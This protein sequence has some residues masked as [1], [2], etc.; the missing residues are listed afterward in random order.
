MMDE[1][2]TKRSSGQ[3][4]VLVV[5]MLVGLIG[6]LALALDGGNVYSMRRQ[7]QLAADAG[8]LAG[9]RAHCDPDVTATPYS[10]ADKY[11]TN[12][13]ATILSF[14]L[15]EDINEVTVETII[16]FDSFFL[17]VLGRPQL[18]VQAL[19]AAR[20]EAGGGAAVLPVAWSCRPP[21]FGG[22]EPGEPG[23]PPGS[24]CQLDV[25]PDNSTCTYPEDAT[26]DNPADKF[27]IVIDSD[28]VG[29]SIYCAEEYHAPEGQNY[30][31]CR[32][33]NCELPV[34]DPE[35]NDEYCA[36]S[37]PRCDVNCDGELDFEILSES[38]FGWMDLDGGG[39]DANELREWVLDPSSA[40]L[41]LVHHW[42]AAKSG[43]AGSV[44]DTVG[45]NL[46][47]AEVV[48][49]VFD[50]FCHGV[51]GLDNSEC[52]WHEGEDVVHESG[53]TWDDY[54]HIIGFANYQITCVDSGPH[55]SC[56][57]HDDWLDLP[58]NVKTIEGCFIK[59]V[60]PDIKDV[61]GGADFD[62]YTLVLSR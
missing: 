62:A 51:P 9:A 12:N 36:S 32:D 22:E 52:V 40:D 45:D 21:D 49:P 47:G 48:V 27:Y 46:I 19:A 23:E 59:G 54:F 29:E 28:D 39:S 30:L 37:Y 7:A 4:L 24:D 15:N 56:R 16:S 18:D 55:K 60:S 5:L 50:N 44:Y 10:E 34:G 42:Y 6:M 43:V 26:E 11:V 13:H 31:D 17:G 57:I 20:C 61:G 38:S 58:P 33:A 8:A 53:G 1:K 2:Q 14:S 25:E 3:V 41:V 35:R